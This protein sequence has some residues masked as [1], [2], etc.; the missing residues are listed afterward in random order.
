MAQNVLGIVVCFVCCSFCSVAHSVCIVC[1]GFAQIVLGIIVCIVCC[2]VLLCVTECV[3]CLLQRLLC[4]TECAS[5]HC[6]CCL[7]QSVFALWQGMCK[8]SLCILS[9]AAFCSVSQNVQGIIVCVACCSQCLL[10]GTECARDHCVYCLLQ[11]MTLKSRESLA[12]N[13]EAVR[14]KFEVTNKLACLFL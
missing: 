2:S 8:G 6:V 10:C 3:C 11:E 12:D 1:C 5:D 9:V 13:M 7:L 14:K 4:G